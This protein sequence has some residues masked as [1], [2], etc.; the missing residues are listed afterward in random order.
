MGSRSASGTPCSVLGILLPTGE[1]SPSA[2]GPP[3]SG[4]AEGARGA[5]RVQPG[6]CLAGKSDLAKGPVQSGTRP[7]VPAGWSGI[8]P[9]ALE[10]NVRSA[11]EWGRVKRVAARVRLCI[12]A[13]D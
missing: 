13:K 1:M 2:A 9:W 3:R 6:Q 4:A 8:A 10:G 11:A 7:A 5:C 12:R